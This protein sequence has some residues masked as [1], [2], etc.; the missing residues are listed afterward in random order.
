[1]EIQLIGQFRFPFSPFTYLSQTT[2]SLIQLELSLEERGHLEG[3]AD[4]YHTAI[5]SWMPHRYQISQPLPKQGGAGGS[6]GEEAEKD[7]TA[8]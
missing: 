3:N 2:L 5:K 8:E 1:M 4:P 6:G 7:K